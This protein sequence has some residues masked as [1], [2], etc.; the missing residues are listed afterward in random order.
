M[1]WLDEDLNENGHC[2]SYL[3]LETQSKFACE[4]GSV[5][6]LGAIVYTSAAVQEEDVPEKSNRYAFDGENSF[7]KMH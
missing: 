3:F 5:P 7:F 2:G 4:K 6:V 1:N